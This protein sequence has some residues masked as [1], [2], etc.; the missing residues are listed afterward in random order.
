MAGG[1]RGFDKGF[2]E[3]YVCVS[4]QTKGRQ[5]NVRAGIISPCLM[6]SD[7]SMCGWNAQK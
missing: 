6:S 5:W 3:L 1:L 7:W 2:E 4:F